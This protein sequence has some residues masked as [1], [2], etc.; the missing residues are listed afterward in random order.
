MKDPEPEPL[1]KVA[2]E[3]WTH[4]GYKI[5]NVYGLK[6]LGLGIICH[7]AIDSLLPRRVGKGDSGFVMLCAALVFASKNTSDEVLWLQVIETNSAK[8]GDWRL[9]VYGEFKSVGESRNL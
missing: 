6:S 5:I 3:F 4:T 7:P 9:W 8:Q 2:A 1:S